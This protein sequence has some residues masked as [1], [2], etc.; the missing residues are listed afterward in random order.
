MY[1]KHVAV[2]GSGP[3]GLFASYLLLTQNFKVTLY[4]KEKGFAKKYLVA[5]SS[6]LNITNAAPLDTFLSKFYPTDSIITKAIQEFPPEAN[7]DFYEQVLKEET[8]I[9]STGH[10]FPKEMKT[11]KILLKW[12]EILK[13]FDD[14]HIA[15]DCTLSK[16]NGSEKVYVVKKG[17]EALIN[18]DYFVYALGGASWSKTGSD[19]K[20]ST[21]FSK[22]RIKVA[23]FAPRNCKFI[24]NWSTHLKEKIETIPLKN[25]A[26]RTNGFQNRGEVLVNKEGIEGQLIYKLTHSIAEEFK[27]KDKVTI[28]LDLLPD[29]EVSVVIGRLKKVRG[30]KS[31]SSQLKKAFNFTTE[32]ITLLNEMRYKTN[33]HDDDSLANLLKGYPI[34]LESPA[35]I[36]EAISTAGGIELSELTENFELKK[37]RNHF[38]IGE[39]LDWSA[40]TGGYLL[41]ACMSCAYQCAREI[42]KRK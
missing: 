39:M 25:C 29:L 4:E 6:G 7:I 36:D 34:L 3:S 11:G 2:F 42:T 15:K 8:F 40:P 5:G 12:M 19:G 35:P 21:I 31:L 30:K 10:I 32:T 23:P 9:G 37:L 13:S 41:T 14:F 1:K 17:K 33:F 38:S 20:W 18:A 24:V 27:S 16:I 26:I 28:F 22:N